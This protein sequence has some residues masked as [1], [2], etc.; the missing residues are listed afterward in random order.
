[1]TIRILAS[2]A[3]YR[4]FDFAAM[5]DEVRTFSSEPVEIFAD[6]G[7]YSAASLGITID[8]KSYLAWLRDWSGVFS[9]KSTLDVIGDAE[10][11]Q[12][13]TE[14]LAS[15]GMEILPVFHVGSP[16]DRLERLCAKH[17]YVALGGMVPY[18]K[19]PEDVM[20]WLVK[21]FIIGRDHGTVF[22]GFGQTKISTIA[23]LPFYSVDSSSW[24]A[25]MKFGR[26]ALWEPRRRNIITI[27]VG[28]PS[29]ARRYASL[30]RDHNADPVRVGRPGFSLR[31]HRTQEQFDQEYQMAAESCAIAWCRAAMWL[32]D[33]H[34]VTPPPGHAETGTSLY[35]VGS[36][37]MDCFYAAQGTDWAIRKGY[38]R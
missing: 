25:G 27:P 16:W 12:R 37:K 21:A 5:L 7:A 26:I 23:R 17:S 15:S 20:R 6:S 33:R 34:R 3:Y 29:Y 24:V 36:D 35:L 22:H 14:Y 11:T 8:I 9:V 13:N 1:M 2:Y 30:L 18:T 38:T 31:G 32:R 4:T 28:V 19:Q 10:A